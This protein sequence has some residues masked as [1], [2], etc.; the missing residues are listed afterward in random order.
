MENIID[1]LLN[2]GVTVGCL[3]YFMFYNN[4]Q[5][6]QTRKTLEDLKEV[7]SELKIIIEHELKK[8]G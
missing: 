8:E 6:E 4:N 1:L 2:N 7:I 5:M 3:V